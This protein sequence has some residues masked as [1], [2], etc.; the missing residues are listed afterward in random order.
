[1]TR[2]RIPDPRT[3]LSQDELDSARANV[4]QAPRLTQTQLD[5]VSRVLSPQLRAT[6]GR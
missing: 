2:Y 1:M 3:V 4:A 6:L 5:L